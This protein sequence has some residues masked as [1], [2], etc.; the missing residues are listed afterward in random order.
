MQGQIPALDPTNENMN[1]V[2][3]VQKYAPDYAGLAGQD[4]TPKGPIEKYA[5]S[6]CERSQH[7]GGIDRLPAPS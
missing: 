1:A 6:L 7:V 5:V 3:K 4:L 2:F